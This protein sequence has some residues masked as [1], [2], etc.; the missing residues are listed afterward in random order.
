MAANR[1]IPYTDL[2]KLVTEYK[3]MTD[4]WNIKTSYGKLDPE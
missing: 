1:L 2:W 3:K 4:E